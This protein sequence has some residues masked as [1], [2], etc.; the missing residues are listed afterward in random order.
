MIR[1]VTIPMKY[2]ASS[3]WKK[4]M[5]IPT[6]AKTLA[7]LVKAILKYTDAYTAEEAEEVLKSEW[8]T[9]CSDGIIIWCDGEV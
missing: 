7:G 4:S 5:E 2:V 3:T 6:R 8:A 9:V 1:R